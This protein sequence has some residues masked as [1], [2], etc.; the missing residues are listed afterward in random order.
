M[1]YSFFWVI[2]RCMNFTCWR[3]WTLCLFHLHRQ[4]KQFLDQRIKFRRWGINQK[5]EYNTSKIFMKFILKMHPIIPEMLNITGQSIKFPN[6][7]V[8][9]SLLKSRK[10]CSRDFCF[11]YLI[12]VCSDLF[13]NYSDYLSQ[14]TLET[15]YTDMTQAG[16]PVFQIIPNKI[17][18]LL[19]Q[20]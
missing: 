16:C 1:L 8:S 14:T 4:G 19:F 2:P 11:L 12:R 9:N 6:S 13:K 18:W 17:S 15:V 20:T 5:K 3:Y 10:I 7:W